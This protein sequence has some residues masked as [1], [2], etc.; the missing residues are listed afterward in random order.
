[1]EGISVYDT[2]DAA[3]QQNNVFRSRSG[4]ARSW[5]SV[6]LHIPAAGGRQQEIQLRIG[7]A[8]DAELL[9]D[10]QRRLGGLAELSLS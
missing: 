3:I 7:V 6:V 5:P 2:L 8:Y 9:A 1:M 10:V 4:P